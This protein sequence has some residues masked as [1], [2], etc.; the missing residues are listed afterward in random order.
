MQ[1]GSGRLFPGGDVLR[2]LHAAQHVGHGVGGLAQIVEIVGVYAHRDAAAGEHLHHGGHERVRVRVHFG[3]HVGAFL[4]DLPGDAAGLISLFEQDVER[5][6]AVGGRKGKARSGAVADGAAD[7]LNARHGEHPRRRLVRRGGRLGKGA[8]LR[9]R[10]RYHH[11]FHFHIGEEREAP[12][13]H[14]RAARGKQRQRGE[15]RDGLVPHRPEDGLFVLRHEARECRLPLWS[16]VREQLACQRRD[17]RERYDETGDERIG[18]REHHIGEELA[19]KALDERDRDKHADRCERGGRDRAADLSCAGHG[20]LDGR[21]AERAQAVCVFDNDDGVIHQHA[22]RYRKT[23]ERHDVDGNAGEVHERER[24][25]QADRDRAERDDRGPP[26]AQK[27]KEDDD[28]E[29]RAPE[30]AR[31]DRVAQQVNV[32]ALIHERGKR[33]PRILRAQLVKDG[34][35]VIGYLRRRVVR[36]LGKHEDKTAVAVERGIDLA[37]VIGADNVRHVAHADGVQPLN[38]EIEQHEI[39]Q[40]FAVG[41][42][43]ADGHDDAVALFVVHIPGG[44]VEILRGD[45]AAHRFQREDAVEIRGVK[46]GGKL[47]FQRLHRRI[48]LRLR[49]R[50]RGLRRGELA[51]GERDLRHAAHKLG[52]KLLELLLQRFERLHLLFGVLLQ[53]S[54]FFLRP[55]DLRA[56]LL[57]LHARR[58]HGDGL[59]RAGGALRGEIHVVQL[60]PRADAAEIGAAFGVERG[61]RIRV[62]PGVLQRRGGVH[63]VVRLAERFGVKRAVRFERD[64]ARVRLGELRLGRGKGVLRLR[65]LR[66]Q[67]VDGG[68]GRGE[69]YSAL[70][71]GCDRIGEIGFAL[72]D[73]LGDAARS[74]EQLIRPGFYRAAVFVQLLLRVLQLLSGVLHRGID[75]VGDLLVHFVELF[76]VDLDGHRPLDH[77]AGRDARHAGRALKRGDHGVPGKARELIAVHF[78]GIDRRNHHGDHVR[79]DAHDARRADR[80][81]P[82]AGEQLRFLENIH[83]GAVHVRV[84]LKFKDKHRIVLRRGGRHGLDIVERRHALLHRLCNDRLDLFRGGARIRRHHNDVGVVH[85]RHQIGGHFD[86]RHH[87]EHQNGDHRDEHGK[88]FFHAERGHG[89][90]SFPNGRSILFIIA[91]RPGECVNFY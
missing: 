1:L 18:E 37:A 22:D 12:C 21:F 27:E 16:R 2:A 8:A 47:I 40:L 34:A 44:H 45:E 91:P 52:G 54:V 13:E 76:L 49:A 24:E 83:H 33:Q 14:R 69:L 23:G 57:D 63:G 11:L 32:I 3:V 80:V 77:A 84:L 62:Q 65:K 60:V 19:R 42:G 89:A 73:G 75:R 86:I 5:N 35:D 67:K 85:V 81:I 36:L 70:S 79:V 41:D 58:F 39:F 55:G 38:A 56:Q 31:K 10:E 20:G 17:E 28:R 26:V 50:E 66:L 88:R 82:A 72:L 9:H 51:A 74:A 53:P 29:E 46:R 6:V 4:V 61:D 90:R 30:K 48:E 43:V 78:G 71:G 64:D 59:R 15:Q 7:G 87:A 68:A 25:K